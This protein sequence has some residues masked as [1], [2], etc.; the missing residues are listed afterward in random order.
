MYSKCRMSIFISICRLS[1][2]FAYGWVGIWWFYSQQ[3]KYIRDGL[4]CILISNSYGH[5]RCITDLYRVFY[6]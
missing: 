5:V 2:R 6:Y 1:R 3:N 4:T